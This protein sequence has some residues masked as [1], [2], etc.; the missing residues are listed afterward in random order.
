MENN[1]LGDLFD[2]NERGMDDAQMLWLVALNHLE[3]VH[4]V[5]FL[6]D[7]TQSFKQLH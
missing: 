7:A 3:G 1:N 5:H 2:G 6:V 4:F